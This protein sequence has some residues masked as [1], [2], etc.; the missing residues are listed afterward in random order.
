MYFLIRVP[1]FNMNP[2]TNYLTRS[3]FLFF[4]QGSHLWSHSRPT[5]GGTRRWRCSRTASGSPYRKSRTDN[6]KVEERCSVFFWLTQDL[7]SNFSA[8]AQGRIQPVRLGGRIY[9]SQVSPCYCERDEVYFTTL[10]L[11][12]Q[13]TPKWPYIALA[14]FL[15]V[16]NHGE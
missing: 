4:R 16:Q 1:A 15:I 6:L 7:I 5:P 12:K 3:C 10:L 9:G 11:T 2:V 8:V 13:W 14:V